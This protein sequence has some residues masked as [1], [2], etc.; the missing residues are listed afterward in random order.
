MPTQ[1][2]PDLYT[3][4]ITE[5]NKVLAQ[6]TQE[7]ADVAQQTLDDLTAMMLAHTL[8]TVQGATALLTGL[9]T[10]LNQVLAMVKTNPPYLDAVKSINAILEAANTRLKAEKKNLLPDNA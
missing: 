5:V 8:D 3:K 7:Q 9:I 1:S 10:E 4:G 6:G 2:I